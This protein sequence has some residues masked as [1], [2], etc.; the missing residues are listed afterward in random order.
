MVADDKVNEIEAEMEGYCRVK[1]QLAPRRLLEVLLLESELGEV[2]TGFRSF[3]NHF[4]LQPPN[5]L[6][7]SFTSIQLRL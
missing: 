3:L 5:T 6:S 2:T 1:L 7:P 4:L